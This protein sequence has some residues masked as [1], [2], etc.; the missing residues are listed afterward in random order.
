[1]ITVH[2]KSTSA[3]L[4]SFAMLKSLADAKQYPSSYQLLREFIFHIIVSKP[5]Y[6]FSAADMKGYLDDYF[7]FSIPEAVIRTSLKGVDGIT[8]ANQMY[9]VQPLSIEASALFDEKKQEA[10]ASSENIVTQICAYISDKLGGARIVEEALM[11]ELFAYLVQDQPAASAKY[12]ELISEFIVKHEKDT[13]IQAGL[14]RICEGGI[15]YL[16]LSHNINETGSLRKPLTLYLGT[17]ILFSLAGYNGK[18]HQDFVLDFF[19]QVRLANS[20]LPSAITLCFFADTKKE[21]DSY[22][23]AAEDIVEGRHLNLSSKPAMTSIVNGCQT[24]ADVRVK[25]ADFYSLLRISYGVIEDT[26]DDYYDPELF[27]VNQEEMLSETDDEKKKK[28]EQAQRY[29]SHIF[30]LRRGKTFSNDLES[31]HLFVTNAKAVLV[32]SKEKAQD[33]QISAETEGRVCG[34]AVSLDRITS[35]LWYKLGNGF[36]SKPYPASVKAA[37]R[38]RTILSSSIAYR[39]KKE[40]TRVKEE[41]EAGKVSDDYVA[42]RIIALR[43]KYI[44]PEELQGENIDEIMDFSPEYLSRFEKEFKERQEALHEKDEIIAQLQEDARRQLAAN[45][46]TIAQQ[47]QIIG[48]QETE[49]AALRERL[50][51][52]ENDEKEQRKAQARRK[53]ICLF[54]WSIVWKFLII[55]VLIF[56]AIKIQDVSRFWS[57]ICFV[58]DF[59]MLVGS[60][61]T[62]FKKD[63]EKYLG[64]SEEKED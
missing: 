29:I 7:S 11:K 63:K 30:K 12:T 28:L 23:N 49:N 24:A 9:S 27:S 57:V 46:E 39:V 17:E 18:I 21:I 51:Q 55:V 14:D 60:L 1:M 62:V 16:G 25:Q 32:M 33:L 43:G 47:T 22:F 31:E 6:S 34:F 59:I 52:Y 41:Y 5:L 64:G 2:E 20:L 3:M 61:V 44:L 35:L 53:N 4:A 13:T 42:A 26:K 37:L 40:Y 19:R 38:A 48:E 50:N 58:F 54:I 45:E 56:V 8:L 10:D 36:S 15:L